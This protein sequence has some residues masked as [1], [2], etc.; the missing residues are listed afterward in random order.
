MVKQKDDNPKVQNLWN[1]LYESYS[2][3]MFLAYSV[4]AM[5]SFLSI[6]FWFEFLER[7]KIY[8]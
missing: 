7:R 4:R 1:N 8:Y 3:D 6:N 2:P 5:V